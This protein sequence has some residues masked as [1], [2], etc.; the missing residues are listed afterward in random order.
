MIEGPVPRQGLKELQAFHLPV[1]FEMLENRQI[2]EQ[3]LI[4][5]GPQEGHP[6]PVASRREACG[7]LRSCLRD[8]PFVPVVLL[9]RAR[10]RSLRAA[11][12]RGPSCGFVDA[13]YSMASSVLDSGAREQLSGWAEP[14]AVNRG[15]ALASQSSVWDPSYLPAVVNDPTGAAPVDGDPCRA[16]AG[17]TAV[18]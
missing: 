11:T 15:S 13:P 6:A 9:Q 16:S 17:G 2:L 4:G 12:V 5:L 1:F 7:P 14:R 3:A 10:K 18:Q 8:G